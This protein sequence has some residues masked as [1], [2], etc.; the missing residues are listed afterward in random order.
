MAMTVCHYETFLESLIGQSFVSTATS[1]PPDG[2]GCCHDNIMGSN[3]AYCGAGML[4]CMK[5]HVWGWGEDK[6]NIDLLVP[7]KKELN[8]ELRSLPSECSVPT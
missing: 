2:N 8:S 7:R 3:H 5:E 4:T 6:R 1:P